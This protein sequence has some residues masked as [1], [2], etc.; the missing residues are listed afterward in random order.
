[1][2]VCQRCNKAGQSGNNVS[3]SKRHTRTRWVPNVQKMTIHENGVAKK[4][5]LCTRCL[6]THYK[7]LMKG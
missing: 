5:S 1:M 4:Q 3:H 7:Q 2:A 6:R